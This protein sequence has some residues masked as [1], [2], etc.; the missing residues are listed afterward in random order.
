V[1]TESGHVLIFEM[2]QKFAKFHLVYFTRSGSDMF[3]VWWDIQFCCMPSS[4]VKN[5]KNRF[6]VV[7]NEYERSRELI[8]A[9][10]FFTRSIT[11][12]S[13][14]HESTVIGNIAITHNNYPV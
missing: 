14:E 11:A 6:K 1:N 7:M 5:L 2:C 4:V 8:S 13:R 10:I 12:S 3:K 9:G